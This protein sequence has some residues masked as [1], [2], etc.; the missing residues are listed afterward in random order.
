MGL[1]CKTCQVIYSVSHGITIV[2]ELHFCIVSFYILK[3][4]HYQNYN[5]HTLNARLQMKNVTTYYKKYSFNE[6]I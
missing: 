1:L 6:E 3:E 4:E 2:F 5:N